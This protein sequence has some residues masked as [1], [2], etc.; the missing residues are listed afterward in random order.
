MI[1]AVCKAGEEEV[2]VICGRNVLKEDVERVA[3][4]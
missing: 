2:V 4:C 3:G 1:N